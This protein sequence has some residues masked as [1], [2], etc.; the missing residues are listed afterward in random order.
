MKFSNFK[1]PGLLVLFFSSLFVFS[2][3]NYAAMA[4]PEPTIIINGDDNTIIINDD[5]TF[6]V[7]DDGT[8]NGG[9]KTP[10][11]V[12]G[13]AF[14]DFFDWLGDLFKKGNKKGGETEGGETEGGETEGGETEG[15]EN[16]SPQEGSSEGGSN[17]PQNESNNASHSSSSG[18]S[19]EASTSTS[20]NTINTKEMV[21]FLN[22]ELNI[23]GARVRE[24]KLML[25]MK[26]NQSCS[27]SIQIKGD[28]RLPRT[29][30][31]AAA[32][33]GNVKLRQGLYKANEQGFLIIPLSR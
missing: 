24:G 14:G 11:G 12:V 13:D 15:G 3:L 20:E 27:A 7:G 6:S 8:V 5:G 29:F 30:P 26:P 31:M 25:K 9:G 17:E 32:K 21:A 18:G 1:S 4:C 16:S 28:V 10:W 22:N 23:M 33:T 2:G 19:T